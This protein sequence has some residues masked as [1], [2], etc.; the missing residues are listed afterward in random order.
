MRSQGLKLEAS[1]QHC[2]HQHSVHISLCIFRNQ[3][4]RLDKS[5]NEIVYRRFSWIKSFCN[6]KNDYVFK[7]VCGWEKKLSSFVYVHAFVCMC[8]CVFRHFRIRLCI[9]ACEFI[10]L[11]HTEQK[12]RS[13]LF[14]PPYLPLVRCYDIT[15]YS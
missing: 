9:Q 1:L 10:Q 5:C 14:V 8:V 12:H 3:Q 6:I 13:V 2:L 4:S 7:F 15:L 11:S